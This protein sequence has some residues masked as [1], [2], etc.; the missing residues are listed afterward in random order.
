MYNLESLKV[1]YEFD[2][3]VKVIL[4]EGNTFDFLKATLKSKRNTC[5]R[6]GGFKTVFKYKNNAVCM[7]KKGKGRRERFI[8]NLQYL[9]KFPPSRD[10][11]VYPTAAYSSIELDLIYLCMPCVLMMYLRSVFVL[12]TMSNWKTLNS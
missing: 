9:I 8:R 4:S 1:L 11:F 5:N 3:I 12:L 2:V 10:F 6:Q 7:V